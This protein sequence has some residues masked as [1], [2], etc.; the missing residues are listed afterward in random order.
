MASNVLATQQPMH[1]AVGH[2]IVAHTTRGQGG[3]RVANVKII[4]V[5]KL[6]NHVRFRSGQLRTDRGDFR[7]EHRLVDAEASLAREGNRG[8]PKALVVTRE[9]PAFGRPGARALLE[10]WECSLDRLTSR[11]DV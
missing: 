1:L 6:K 9:A 4:G 5:G 8:R 3:E 7:G 2:R 11:L 10:Q